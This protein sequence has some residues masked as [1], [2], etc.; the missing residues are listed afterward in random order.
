[1]R[2]SVIILAILMISL[3]IMAAFLF[4]KR[5][6]LDDSHHLPSLAKPTYRKLTSDDYGLISDYLSYFG[7]SDFSSGYSLQN[8]PEMPIK[9]E[10]VT[11]LRNIVNR[12]A[13]SSEGLNHWRYYIDAVEI[14]IPPLLVPYLQQENVLDVVCTPSIPIVIGVNG[15]FLKDEKIHFSALSLKQLS[16]PIL[17]NG[18]ST[19][20]KNEGDAA[21]LLQIR[22]ETNEEYRLHNSSG[23]WD[24]SFV[25]I[26]LTLWLTALM[27]PQVFLP[28]ILAI[29]SS[30]LAIG[31][32]LI[33]NPLIKPRKQEVHCF[34]GRLKRWGLF[35]NFDHGQVK[36]VSLGGIDLI[37]PPHWEPYIQ[38]YID[39]VTY[40]EMYPSHHVIKQGSYLSLHDEEK[41][42]PYKRYIKNII[43]VFWSLFIIGMLYLYQPLSLSMKLSFSW[44][45]DTEP[46]LVTNFTELETTDLHV[47]DIIQ[48][49][50]VGMCYMPP[51]LSSKNNK[52]I[53]AP[54]DCSGIYWNNSNPMPMPESSTI[55]KAAALLHMVEEQLHPVS[56]N[57]VNPS[58]GQAITK[59]GM[60]LLDNF[61]GIVL[62]TQDL[63]P[64]EN[65]CIRLKMALVNLS[66]VNDW[67]A[68]VQRAESGKLTGTNVLLRAVSAEA[69]EKLI[70]TTTSSFIYREIDKAAIL[71]NSPPPGGVLLISDERKQL[72]DYAS[73]SNSVFEPTPLE[74]WR[75]LQRLSD[76]LLHTPFDTGGVITGMVVDANG[77]LQIFLHSLPDSMTMLYYI[78]NTLLLFLAIGFLVLNLFLIIRRRR[79]NNQRMNKI[80]LYY[81]HCFYRPPQ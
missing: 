31:I 41:N 60:N 57:R 40:L 3:F 72:V 39:K 58:L 27:M 53:F 32:F 64:R 30:F 16:E 77:T 67:A 48:A 33:H 74:Q 49:K 21:H 68:L 38:G 46:H 19:I 44:L 66:N 24:G 34:K 55:E 43:F 29:G 8:F 2:L 10:V 22:E 52:T 35:G 4:F 12:F 11:T 70:D 65:E 20:Q 51:N 54:F 9:G 26:G 75:E 13:G 28:W 18:S 42:Y 15:H 47:G 63:C 6:R 56:N 25:C 80:S 59:S 69:L 23:F 78:G 73:N 14:H 79:Q 1:M 45:K 36:N 81:E 50:G 5:R 76:I 61:D 17:A 71:L 7:T 37:Y 62:K